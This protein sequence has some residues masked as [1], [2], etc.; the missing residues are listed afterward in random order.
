MRDETIVCP[1]DEVIGLAVRRFG[2]LLFRVEM[3][4]EGPDVPFDAV[5]V[6]VVETGSPIPAPVPAGFYGTT[7][8]LR[9]PVDCRGGPSEYLFLFTGV[10]IVTSEA[11]GRLLVQTRETFVPRDFVAA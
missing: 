8:E 3:S 11:E 9:V 4:G 7:V 2:D 6:T 5:V 1:T 10:L